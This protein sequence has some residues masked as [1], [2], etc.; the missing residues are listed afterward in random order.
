MWVPE[1]RERAVRMVEE[2][3]NETGE[4]HGVV[5]RITVELGLGSQTLRHSVNANKAVTGATGLAGKP[6]QVG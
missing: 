5:T 4:H 3:I 2:T 1:L 6:R